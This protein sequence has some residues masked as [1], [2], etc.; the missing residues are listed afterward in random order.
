MRMAFPADVEYLPMDR[1][2]DAHVVDPV[3]IEMEMRDALRNP[4]GIL[5][6]GVTAALV[7]ACVEHA[8]GGAL[9]GDVVLNYLAP[10]RIGPV[11]ARAQLLGRRSDGHAVRV[12]VRDVGSDRVTAVAVA[13]AAV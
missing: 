12:E 5:H 3:T 9:T 6:G 8:T 4:W 7:D 13:T 11:R 10:N 1:W 2:L